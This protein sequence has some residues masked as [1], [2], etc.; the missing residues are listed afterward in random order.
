MT[1]TLISKTIS[2]ERGEME[3]DQK[4]WKETVQKVR[5]AM[6]RVNKLM[7]STAA[8]NIFLPSTMCDAPLHAD[9]RVYSG[10]ITDWVNI[11]A[12]NGQFH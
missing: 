2:K 5:T 6:K 3:R 11:I 7:K 4:R 8:R 10:F 9:E 1:F 12:R